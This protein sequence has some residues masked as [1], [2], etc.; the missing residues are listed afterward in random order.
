V[1]AADCSVMPPSE[2]SGKSKRMLRNGFRMG[3]TGLIR[4]WNGSG[5]GLEWFVSALLMGRVR[6]GS[7]LDWVGSGLRG[8][9][10]GMIIGYANGLDWFGF[11]LV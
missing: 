11:K 4:V 1:K 2:D 7:C 3:M 6:I 5:S 8:I 10:I 9:W